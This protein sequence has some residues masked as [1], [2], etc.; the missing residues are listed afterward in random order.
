[1]LKVCMHKISY[2]IFKGH[3]TDIMS[4][5]MS[6]LVF[7]FKTTSKLKKKL[8]GHFLWMGFNCLKG[9]ESL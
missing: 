5:L 9:T 3:V 8:S 7:P 2:Q 1:M 6:F 4:I